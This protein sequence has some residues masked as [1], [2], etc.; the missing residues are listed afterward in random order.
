MKYSVILIHG[1]DFSNID[2]PLLVDATNFQGLNDAIRSSFELG[3]EQLHIA[4]CGEILTGSSRLPRDGAL[5][6]V[7]VK[8]DR[9]QD[10]FCYDDPQEPPFRTEINVRSTLKLRFTTQ[11]SDEMGRH[12]ISNVS[13]VAFAR[14]HAHPYPGL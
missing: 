8:S 12:Q 6:N 14:T 7:S 1:G 2:A 9:V 3:P 4:Y 11:N 13:Y 10:A 5:L